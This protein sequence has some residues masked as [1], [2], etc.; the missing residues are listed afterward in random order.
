MVNKTL[1][2]VTCNE[3]INHAMIMQMYGRKL[4]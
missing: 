2:L 4:N 3:V 1:M